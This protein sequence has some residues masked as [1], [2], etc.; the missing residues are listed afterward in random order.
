MRQYNSVLEERTDGLSQQQLL[1][2]SPRWTEKLR[3]F[4]AQYMCNSITI[5]ASLMDVTY[6]GRVRQVLCI[7]CTSVSL[8]EVLACLSL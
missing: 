8:A 5:I 1:V 6:Y 7:A 3:Q 4:A 2:F